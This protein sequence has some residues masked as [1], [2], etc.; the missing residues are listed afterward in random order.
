[1]Y[2]STKNKWKE[3]G[4]VIVKNLINKELI[5][6]CSYFMN[7]HYTEKNVCTDFGSNNHELEFI[8]T[9]LDKLYIN[10]NIKSV[11]KLLNKNILLT[12]ADAWSKSGNNKIRSNGNQ[13]IHMDYGNHTFLHINDWDEPEAV[14]MIIYLSDIKETGG[15]TAVVKRLGKNDELYKKPYINMP[16]QANYDF[17]NDKE[18]AETYFKSI[19]VNVYN[20]RQKLYQREIITQPSI[21]DILFYR[22]DTWHRGTPVLP[23]KIR[24]VINLVWK[25]RDCY[26]IQQ[27]NIGF[28]K[29]MYDG[30]LEKIFVEMTPL[31]RSVFGVPMP[32]DKY[33]TID[34][35][36]LL[37]SRYPNINIKPYII[38]ISKL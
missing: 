35:V 26:W 36:K 28:T 33:W 27:W 2:L 32:G 16:G 24:N 37:I 3:D 5:N 1:M 11:Q 38:S 10:E 21:G 17:Y 29:K 9:I 23:G 18:K 14:A 13:R 19:D 7:N 30:V 15:G 25:K 8:Y 34:K 4:Y 22:L 6:K 20:F 31:Q 12:Q